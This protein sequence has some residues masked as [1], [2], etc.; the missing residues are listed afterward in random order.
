[1]SHLGARAATNLRSVAAS[2]RAVA[3]PPAAGRQ[4]MNLSMPSS[5]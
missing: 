3:P 1:L 5:Y 4:A 2:P